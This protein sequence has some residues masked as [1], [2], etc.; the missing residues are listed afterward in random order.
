MNNVNEPATGAIEDIINSKETDHVP[1][2]TKVDIIS[3]ET[4]SSVSI[5][6]SEIVKQDEEV[7]VYATA[8]IDNSMEN[9]FNSLEKLVYR[10]KHLKENISSVQFEEYISR[11]N[12][13]GRFKHYVE[14][15]LSVRTSN[16][17]D[18]PRSYVYRHFGQTEWSKGNGVKVTVNR[19]HVKT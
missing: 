13:N 10:E 6:G 9:D 4:V 5:P 3:I 8:V 17:W 18:G 1:I 15:R 7:I 14:M 12:R 2:E 11:E 19:I 16:L